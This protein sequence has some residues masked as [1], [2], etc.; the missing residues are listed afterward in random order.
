MAY[1]PPE[2]ITQV[3][4]LL[5][6]IADPKT[7][8]AK[9]SELAAKDAVLDQKLKDIQSIS[10]DT[11]NRM[12]VAI[13]KAA[14]EQATAEKISAEAAALMSEYTSARTALIEIEQKLSSD[15]VALSQREQDVEQKLNLLAN[16]ESAFASRED[17]VLHRERQLVEK[18]SELGTLKAQLED[19]LAKLKA[20]VN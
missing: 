18:E 2:E 10:D 5:A 20:V 12:E 6:C 1:L 8:E 4:S 11:K 15:R 17:S 9:L 7:F 13:K 16:R 14:E 19:K 3:K